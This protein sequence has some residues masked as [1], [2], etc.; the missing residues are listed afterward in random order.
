MISFTPNT[1]TYALPV[2]SSAGRKVARARLGI[3][4]H[5]QYNGNAM[6]S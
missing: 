4:F 3:V 1:I 5:T 2:D 6:D